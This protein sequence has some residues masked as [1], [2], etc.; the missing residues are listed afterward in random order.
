MKKRKS[1]RLLLVTLILMFSLMTSL[2]AATEE[3]VKVTID[4][5]L[6]Q[7]AVPPT[8]INGRTLVPFRTIFESLGAEVD[9]DNDEKIAYGV[10][11][12]VGIA[13]QIG[14]QTAIIMTADGST[15]ELT[16]EAAPAIVN[17]TTM[18]SARV[19]AET[20]GG[21]VTWKNEIRTVEIITEQGLSAKLGQIGEP[22]I[23][24]QLVGKWSDI[25]NYGD[26]FDASGFYVRGSNNA[27]L[28]SFNLDGTFFRNSVCSGSI[29]SGQIIT[30]GNY[31]VEGD[32]IILYNKTVTWIPDPSH[33]GQRDAYYDQPEADEE[34]PFYF[35]EDG[36]L[37]LDL[38]GYDRVE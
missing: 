19:V 4:G 29:I 2:F 36:R 32:K 13:L 37:M 38:F 16:L 8:I 22:A 23:V 17:N 24:S 15:Y 9:W 30:N 33:P 5:K 3:P 10:T 26:Y 20:L 28:I 27:T 31:R 25:D 7:F 11:E 18:V 14:N 21:L 1:V 6:I 34:E 35:T 12:E